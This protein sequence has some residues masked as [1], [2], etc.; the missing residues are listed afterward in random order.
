[1]RLNDI[2]RDLSTIEQEWVI[3]MKRPWGE[4]A[5]SIVVPLSASLTVPQN[6]KEQ[7]FDYFLE[8]SVVREVV[9]VLKG[10]HI[11]E[12]DKVKLLLYYA[13][14]DAYPDWVYS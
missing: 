13:E 2:V 9:G 6:V 11:S 3:C 7:G 5:E 4:F 14:N 1:M 8:I 12:E 10:K